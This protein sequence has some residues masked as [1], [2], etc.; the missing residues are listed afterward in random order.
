M[1]ANPQ[2][3]RLFSQAWPIYPVTDEIN[4]FVINGKFFDRAV[5]TGALASVD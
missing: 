3:T 1:F 4:L 5:K 2:L